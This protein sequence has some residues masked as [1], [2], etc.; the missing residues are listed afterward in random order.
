MLRSDASSGRETRFARWLLRC[1][2]YQLYFSF[3]LPFVW[4]AWRRSVR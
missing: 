1:V 4:M 3:Y 2:P